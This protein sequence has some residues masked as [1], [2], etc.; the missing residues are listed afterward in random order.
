MLQSDVT[1]SYH[2]GQ[3]VLEVRFEEASQVH[4]DGLLTGR[5][6]G[7]FLRAL[8]DWSRQLRHQLLLQGA[9]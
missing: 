9:K 8:S 6:G 2:A 3:L 7:L 1:V 4:A 5:G